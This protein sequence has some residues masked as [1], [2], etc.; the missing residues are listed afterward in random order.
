[1]R[2]DAKYYAHSHGE[3]EKS[4]WHLLSHHL[5]STGEK[6]GSFLSIAGGEDLG[7]VIGLL[8]DLGK[9]SSEFQ[10]RL[11]GSIAPVDHSTAGAKIAV[12]RYGRIGKLIAFCVAGY[13]TGLANG[14]RKMQ[15]YAVEIPR[16]ARQKLLDTSASRVAGS[17]KFGDQFVELINEAMVLNW[18]EHAET[19]VSLRESLRERDV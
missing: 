15:P 17:E 5:V 2:K 10:D 19:I 14:V 1:M 16:Q 18:I 4:N 6:P 13:H 3:A 12:E 9:Y 11:A 8:H 7:R